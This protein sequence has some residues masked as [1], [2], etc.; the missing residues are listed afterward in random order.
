[1]SEATTLPRSARDE[2]GGII[3]VPRLCDKIRLMS[4]GT[5]HPDFHGN[6]GLGMDLWTCQFL[7]VAYEDLK[8]QVLLGA[9]DE[10]ALA[11]AREN[12]IT[13]PDYELAWFHSYMSNRGFR[14]DMSQ[15]LAE[16]KKESPATDRDDIQSFMDY[17][18]V[19]EGRTL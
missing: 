12:G 6:L 4:A 8:A 13:R 16:R 10:D 14:D 5:L 19:D 1:M 3:Y 18:E 11:W 9:T 17:I 7:G 15:R 2:I